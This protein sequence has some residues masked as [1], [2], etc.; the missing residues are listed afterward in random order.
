MGLIKSLIRT[1][2]TKR[3]SV[4]L[5]ASLHPPKKGI[6]K[7]TSFLEGDLIS[8]DLVWQKL[9]PAADVVHHL[10]LELGHLLPEDA[11]RGCQLGVLRLQTLNLVLQPRYPLQLSLAAL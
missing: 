1:S 11:G 3:H 9:A 6:S 2:G 4:P 10:L 7:E 8:L 5:G